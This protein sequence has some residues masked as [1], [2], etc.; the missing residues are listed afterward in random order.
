ME[1][2]FVQDDKKGEFFIQE[3]DKKI[4][5]MTFVYAGADTII[6]DHTFVNPAYEGLGLGKQ[7]LSKAITFVAEKELKII[8]LCPFVKKMVAITPDYQ[9]Y[10][11]H[12]N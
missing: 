10:L 2:L 4:A 7:M 3:D 5:E 12:K 6:F 11:R 1:V 9:Q 8:P